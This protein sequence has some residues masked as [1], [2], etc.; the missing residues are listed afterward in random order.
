[1]PASDF[2]VGALGAA[3]C[4]SSGDGGCTEFSGQDYTGGTNMAMWARWQNLTNDA[5]SASIIPNLIFTDTAASG[6]VGTKGVLGPGNAA[7]KNLVALPVTPTV[8]K[9]RY[10]YVYG[11]PA[12]I[13][14][15]LLVLITFFALVVTCF[16]GIGF[17]RMRIHL[18]QIS[19]G[20]I[21]TTFLYPGPGGM[22]MRSREWVNHLG[23]KQID[24]SGDFPLAAEMMSAP[25]K[26]M[27][28]TSFERGSDVHSAE[29]EVLMKGNHVREASQGDIGYGFPQPQQYH[30][31]YAGVPQHPASPNP[32]NPQY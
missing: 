9:I 13:S 20:R 27:V 21:Y 25:E 26:G 31:Q 12:F 30:S 28:V 32:A 7:Q 22:T 8:Q 2:A 17:Q 4:V 18:Q 24:L 11:I 6:V 10:H 19:P 15:L 3:Y 1:M 29:G 14:V 23:R 5:E 16:R